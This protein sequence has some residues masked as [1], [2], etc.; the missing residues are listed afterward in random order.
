MQRALEEAGFAVLHSANPLQLEV[1][2]RASSFAYAQ[3]ALV[4]AAT[5]IAL[6]C[7]YA[8]SALGRQRLRSDLPWLRLLLTCEFGAVVRV[9]PELPYC[10]AVG[11]L[12]KPFDLA[13]LQG[14]AYR[15]RTTIEG[16]SLG[17][18][19]PSSRPPHSQR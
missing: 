1:T 18:S 16:P 14:I 8:A 3:Q 11:L 15:C 13:L 5:T 9:P 2:L 4:V 17:V 10:I 7:A 19:V 12:E 6:P